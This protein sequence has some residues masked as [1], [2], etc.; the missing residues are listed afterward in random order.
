MWGETRSSIEFL[1]RGM[2]KKCVARLVDD[3][4]LDDFELEYSTCFERGTSR[5]A[6][7]ASCC[8]PAAV[9]FSVTGFCCVLLLWQ[10]L[11]PIFQYCCIESSLITLPRDCRRDEAQLLPYN[12][13]HHRAKG[14]EHVSPNNFTFKLVSRPSRFQPTAT[15]RPI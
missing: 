11:L 7:I 14:N 10:Q 3:G 8:V 1:P 12:C 5:G 6:A 4:I 13:C 2:W 15:A 9:Y